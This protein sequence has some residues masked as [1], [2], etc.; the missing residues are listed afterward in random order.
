MLKQLKKILHI[1]THPSVIMD[2]K[3]CII[4]DAN[5]AYTEAHPHGLDPSHF[6]DILNHPNYCW[7]HI[8]F[9]KLVLII[10]QTRAQTKP[11][12]IYND[13]NTAQLHKIKQL[14]KEIEGHRVQLENYDFV[15]RV[16]STLKDFLFVV[17]PD[18]L[19]LY[20]NETAERFLNIK[21]KSAL[22]LKFCE[23]FLDHETIQS[24]IVSRDYWDSQEAILVNSQEVSI[25]VLMSSSPLE[26]SAKKFSGFVFLAKDV[27]C[28]KNMLSSLETEKV[29]AQQASMA[30]SQF[31]S[32]MSHELRTPLNAIIGYSELLMEEAED[33]CFDYV[34]KHVPLIKGSGAYLLE[35]INNI[36]DIAK[37]ESGRSEVN[38]TAVGLDQIVREVR[39]IVEPLASK[40][41][42]LLSFINR[43]QISS[44]ESDSRR[45]KQILVNLISNALKFTKDG[46]VII[47]FTKDAEHLNIVVIDNGIGIAADKL[48]H[49]FEKFVQ[50]HDIKEE[51]LS[52]S[53]LGLSIVSSFL[54]L[55][56]GSIKVSS[57]LGEGTRFNI[58]LPLKWNSFDTTEP[59]PKEH[60][61]T[62]PQ[63]LVVDDDGDVRDYMRTILQERN[64]KVVEAENVNEA[65][66]ILK[67][68]IPISAILTDLH[69]PQ[70]SGLELIK[71]TSDC[72]PHIPI[73][74]ISGTML[75]QL[76][77]R[78]KSY[79]IKLLIKPFKDIEL[80]K[81]TEKLI[82]QSLQLKQDHARARG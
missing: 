10:Q 46:S 22:G 52:G 19:I 76:V 36:L 4:I 8:S 20:L 60:S 72:C 79:N 82:E 41:G 29:N 11:H 35:L 21:S 44:I 2:R 49:I 47:E 78:C 43:D 39:S 55:L 48:D 74:V 3:T 63:I 5:R 62:G 59:L 27:T 70:V 57:K 24:A 66:E 71:F 50:L 61:G 17:S 54:E 37:I 23:F 80:I 45:L 18:G 32:H 69:M 12:A 6:R 31:L 14:K 26:S 53:G 25:P 68:G 34:E 77:N 13:E 67:S 65:I 56:K 1:Q 30:K 40:T 51:V 42:N 9:E 38:I 16:I 64:Y 28:F 58:S 81:L 73:A 75:D 7:E 33:G 15:T